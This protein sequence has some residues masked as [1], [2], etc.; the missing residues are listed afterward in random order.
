M[1]L[2]QHERS[3]L[4]LAEKIQ[5]ERARHDKEMYRLRAEYEQADT[6]A[7]I[8]IGGFDSEKMLRARAVIDVDGEYAKAGGERAWAVDTAV[9]ALLAGGSPL[10]TEYVGTKTYAHWSG[11]SITCSYGCGPRHGSVCFSIGLTA[12]VRS[13]ATDPLLT[14]QEIDDAVFYLRNLERIQQAEREARAAAAAA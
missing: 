10:R 3:K 1:T 12:G 13:R 14:E 5:A 4:A 7:R 2:A 11:Q 9:K 6:A 8:A